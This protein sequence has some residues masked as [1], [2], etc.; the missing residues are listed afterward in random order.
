MQKMVMYHSYQSFISV[1]NGLYLDVA[2]A[3]K[4]NG[5]NVQVYEQNGTDSQKFKLDKIEEIQQL[6]IEEGI[7]YIHTKLNEEN[8]LDIEGKLTSNSANVQIWRESDQ[9]TRNQM[10]KIEKT[11]DGY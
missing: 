2:G 7:Y 3:S 8:V 4:E 5:A 10:F 9:K 1:C 11:E 6:E